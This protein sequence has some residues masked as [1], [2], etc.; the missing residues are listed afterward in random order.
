[1]NLT[2][3]RTTA[4]ICLRSHMLFITALATSFILF[5]INLKAPQIDEFLAL[6]LS[7]QNKKVGTRIKR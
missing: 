5:L 4:A 1:M 6:F 7:I 3:Y 2:N